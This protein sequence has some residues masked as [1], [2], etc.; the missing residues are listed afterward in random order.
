MTQIRDVEL[1][2]TLAEALSRAV[3]GPLSVDARDAWTQDEAEFLQLLPAPAPNEL[4]AWLLTQLQQLAATGH[5]SSTQAAAVCLIR[6]LKD[7]SSYPEIKSSLCDLQNT[8]LLLLPTDI[9]KS[10][11]CSYNLHIFCVLLLLFHFLLYCF[12]N[13]FALH[14]FCLLMCVFYL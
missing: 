11:C 9:G 8:F 7:C 5:P 6:I 2:F 4:L 1:H 14:S 13:P 10:R 3:L 12:L